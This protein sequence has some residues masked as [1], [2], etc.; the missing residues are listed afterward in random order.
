MTDRE[1]VEELLN[2]FLY[3]KRKL[4]EEAGHRGKMCLDRAAELARPRMEAMAEVIR[5]WF[6]EPDI[7]MEAVFAWAKHNKHPDGPM[8]NMFKS[9]K[10]IT[11]ALGYYLQ[12]PYEVVVD[13]RSQKL[14]LERRDFEFTQMRI[15]LEQAGV[16]DLVSATSYPVE[17]RYLLAVNKFQMMAAFYMAPELLKIME[18]DRRVVK[19]LAH[20][21][22]KYER[23]AAHFNKQKSKLY[24]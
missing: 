17:V 5:D 13:K 2:N 3:Q 10:Y 20:R 12:V 14:F 15:E 23:V 4:L 9:V 24:A 21:G 1:L 16:T 8:P 6:V 11:S 7:V 18:S 22:V 19:W